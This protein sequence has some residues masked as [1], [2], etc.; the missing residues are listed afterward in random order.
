MARARRE[1]AGQRD[2]CIASRMGLQDA[3]ISSVKPG[4]EE[5]ILARRD[6]VEG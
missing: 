4:E 1:H 5:Q 3:A 6:A 2:R